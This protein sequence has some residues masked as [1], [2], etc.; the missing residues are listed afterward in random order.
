ML[1]PLTL[2]LCCFCLCFITTFLFFPILDFLFLEV[3][4]LDLY[5]FFLS[6][7]CLFFANPLPP[8]KDYSFWLCG[9]RQV[10]KLLASITALVIYFSFGSFCW[11]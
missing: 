1:L 5:L 4:V 7:P 2:I 8:I 11:A 6:C 9:M 3:D 10:P